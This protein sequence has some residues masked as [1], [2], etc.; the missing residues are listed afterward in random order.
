MMVKKIAIVASYTF[1]E[2]LK[3]KI[4][5][6]V[7]FVGIGLM[8][9]TYV[10]TEFTYGVPERVALDFGLGMLSLS[11]LSISLFLGVSLLSKEIESRTVYMVIS[12]PVPRFAFIL[13]KLL[14]LMGIQLLNILILGSLT[15][16]ATYFLGG[17]IDPL[18]LWSIGFTF[19][20]SLM[21]LLLVVFV[22]LFANNILSVL[23]SVVVLLLGHFIQDTKDTSLVKQTPLLQKVLDLYEFFLPAFYKLNL[24]DFVVYNKNLDLSYLIQSFSYGTLYSAFLLLMIVSIFNRK[25]LD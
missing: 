6:N 24:K 18:V 15:L 10:A 13:G 11:S 17:N 20:E 12:R 21:L 4:L 23:L 19:L 8:V 7:F 14:G 22:S 1:R 25:N 2:I 9:V 16:M 3:S 5:L